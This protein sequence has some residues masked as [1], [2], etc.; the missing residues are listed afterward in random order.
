MTRRTNIAL[1][2]M[3]VAGAASSAHATWSIILIDTRTREVGI[4]SATCLTGFD[5]RQ[6][7]P[8]V[9]TGVGAAA[10]QSFV[11]STLVTRTFIR[12]RLLEG[13]NP[14]DII[15]G[16]PSVDAN[17]QRRQYG[18]ADAAG[19]ST[20]F[21]GSFAGQW[22][23]GVNG[24]FS[25]TYAGS[26]GTIS[27]AIQGNVLTGESVITTALDAARNTPGDLPTRLMA[28][29]EAARAQGGDGRCSCSP[30]TPTGCGAPPA[31]FTTSAQIGYVIVA[32]LGDKDRCGG[33]YPA[34]AT[35]EIAIG[36]FV[37]DAAIDV[38]ATDQTGSL[39][40]YENSRGRRNALPAFTKGAPS[41][42]TGTLLAIA[43]N[44]RAIAAGNLLGDARQDLLI[45][46]AFDNLPLSIVR[47]SIGGQFDAPFDFGNFP[48][49][50]KVLTV[51][52]NRDGFQDIATLTSNGILR[53]ERNEGLFTQRAAV[54]FSQQPVDMTILDVDGDG[55]QDF[56]V[57]L[58]PVG[59]VVIVENQSTIEFV[60]L[61]S[62]PAIT[63][64]G[65]ARAI[66]AGNFDNDGDT[67][68][69]VAINN[70]AS[71]FQYIRNDAGTLM[72]RP[73]VA[74]R[75]TPIAITA[76][77]VTG[78]GITDL[79]VGGNGVL[80]VHRGAAASANGVVFTGASN[81]RT[82][83]IAGS[84]T[85]MAT[86]DADGDGDLDIATRDSQG[87]VTILENRGPNT[88]QLFGTAGT[89]VTTSGCADGDYFLSLNVANV[90]TTAPDVVPILRQQ[91]D[92]WRSNLTSK[93]DGVQSVVSVPS[94]TTA[95]PARYMFITLRDWQAQ[96]V[97]TPVTVT[98][99]RTGAAGAF[100]LGAVEQVEPGTYRVLITP[101][102]VPVVE[103]LRISVQAAGGRPV[104]LMPLP[105]IA[106]GAPCDDIDFNNNTVFPEDADVIDF[107]RVLAG[108]TC[109]A[110]N[111]IDFNANGVF[112]EDQDVIDFFTVLAGG[113]C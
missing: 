32:R 4:A 68:L 75:A 92:A 38:A 48:A 64:A 52:V 67:D 55:D 103:Q 15:A 45:G 61:V 36:D 29:M 104:V 93:V 106:I 57:A 56:A 111:S 79:L 35:G 84:P 108:E 88:G 50:R 2:L 9:V 28:A 76:G 39:R 102:T 86:L 72:V 94:L 70:T 98:I 34:G 53:I 89:W 49:V 90:P 10:A 54:T 43:S 3:S 85:Q 66:A 77:D 8:V 78:D 31:D 13:V 24:Q 112:P 65:P 59:E 81:L 109:E 42:A 105:A 21:T 73:A 44:P 11:E 7:S 37:G 14:A 113:E 58:A 1:G 62:R 23:G 71:V 27:Y 100:V 101:G 25:Y 97:T 26:T 107:F 47:T 95:S 51:D 20:T 22:A 87:F 40:V 91:F 5:L 30:E 63:L 82:G 110:C 12:D 80:A 17:H 16:L 83:G 18:I 99:D 69:A 33:V 74:A 60:Q 6:G 19:R 96:V 41:L 46:R